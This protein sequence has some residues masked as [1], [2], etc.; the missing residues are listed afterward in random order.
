MITLELTGG[1]GNQLFE[2]AACYAL[3]QK[4]DQV[5]YLFASY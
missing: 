1:L 5:I 2:Y 3:A 4:K